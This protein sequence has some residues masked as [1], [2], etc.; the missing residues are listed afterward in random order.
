MNE[1]IKK[2]GIELLGQQKKQFS[3]SVES[4]MRNWII[5]RQKWNESAC[6]W[7]SLTKKWHGVKKIAY[8]NFLLVA[9]WKLITP[10]WLEISN[11]V[12]YRDE[13]GLH[14]HC[15]LIEWTMLWNQRLITWAL[16]RD[17]FKTTKSLALYISCHLH[18]NCVLIL[19][20]VFTL[21]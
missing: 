10:C 6:V 16:G 1:W 12:D 15:L 9:F 14:D 4:E 13:N 8:F 11:L 21:S 18:W 3:V 19:H 7:H 17:I 20:W 2:V 5:C